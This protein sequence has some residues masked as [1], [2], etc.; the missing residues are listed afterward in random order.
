MFTWIDDQ[1]WILGKWK[2]IDQKNTTEE[3]KMRPHVIEFKT[4]HE[5][6][7]IYEN[8]T[9]NN[10]YHFLDNAY[11]QTDLPVV[12]IPG[13]HDIPYVCHLDGNRLTLE[14]RDFIAPGREHPLYVYERIE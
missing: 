13:G 10:V 8:E 6:N 14:S 3:E 11:Y 4:G 2:Y 12:C 5:A 9:R 7:Y 1:D